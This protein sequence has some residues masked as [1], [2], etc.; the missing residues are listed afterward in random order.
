MG[1][2]SQFKFLNKRITFLFFIISDTVNSLIP[3]AKHFVLIRIRGFDFCRALER[4]LKFMPW[5]K[6]LAKILNV[7]LLVSVGYTAATND[8]KKVLF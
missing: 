3:K 8:C 1:D 5:L 6:E 7:L 2:E 4:N